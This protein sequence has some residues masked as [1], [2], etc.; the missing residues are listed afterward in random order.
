ME[1]QP[2]PLAVLDNSFSEEI[3]PN[4]QS[5]FP[6]V[7]LEAISSC[8]VLSLGVIYMISLFLKSLVKWSF[9]LRFLLE[10]YGL[11]KDKKGK[12]LFSGVAQP[13]SICVPWGS[14]APS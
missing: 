5:K 13:C 3:F 6:L 14:C 11:S 4:V 12:T 2:L 9:H 1:T 10:M 7:L 8:P